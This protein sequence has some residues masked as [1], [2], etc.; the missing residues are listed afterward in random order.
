MCVIVLSGGT[1]KAALGG[2]RDSQRGTNQRE[3]GDRWSVWESEGRDMGVVRRDSPLKDEYGAWSEQ[4]GEPQAL[5]WACPTYVSL[6][7]TSFPARR[8]SACT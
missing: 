3:V 7:P 6:G 5:R 8:V 2:L 4:G 1:A